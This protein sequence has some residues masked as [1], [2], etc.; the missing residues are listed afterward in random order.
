[1]LTPVI[2]YRN[3]QNIFLLSKNVGFNFFFLLV[4]LVTFLEASYVI[5]FNSYG[6]GSIRFW[7]FGHSRVKYRLSHVLTKLSVN[8]NTISIVSIRMIFLHET[9]IPVQ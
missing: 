6:Y 3:F 5:Y 9:I 4:R 1:M 7:P 2:D 8:V